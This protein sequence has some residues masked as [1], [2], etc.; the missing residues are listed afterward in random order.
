[1][2][3]EQLLQ[4]LSDCVVNMEEDEVVTIAEYYLEEGY[5][6]FDGIMNGL[7]DGMNQASSTMKKNIL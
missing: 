2:T 7:V 4:K 5:P 6:A 3:K 1:M